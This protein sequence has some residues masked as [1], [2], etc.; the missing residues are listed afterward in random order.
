MHAASGVKLKTKTGG[1]EKALAV[2]PSL[3]VGVT[4][5]PDTAEQWLGNARIVGRMMAAGITAKAMAQALGVSQS[6]V[7][8]W[9]KAGRRWPDTVKLIVIQKPECF[10][11]RVLTRLAQRLWT[12]IDP[13][14]RSA[15]RDGRRNGLPT[16]SLL[17]AVQ[18]LAQGEEPRRERRSIAER[19]ERLEKLANSERARAHRLGE[20]LKKVK[21]EKRD[22][23]Q[24]A[25]LD[26]IADAHRTIAQLRHQLA[27]LRAGKPGAKARSKTPDEIY[28]E[29]KIR[30]RLKCAV[31][32][33]PDEGSLVIRYGNR[34]V[35][36]GIMEVLK[37]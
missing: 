3:L 21:D 20:E 9:G 23:E 5:R 7:C 29:D 34:D 10:H 31:F 4:A 14:S 36:D 28:L 6:M 33:A 15:M 11:P 35:L 22:L 30:S 17:S 18:L 16:Q 37:V 26:S 1:R 8:L 32:L 19:A 24:Q 25:S 12:D 2:A 13:R 27:L